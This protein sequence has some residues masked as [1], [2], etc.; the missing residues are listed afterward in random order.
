MHPILLHV[1]AGDSQDCKI[2]SPQPQCLTHSFIPN[3][4]SPLWDL[5]IT[6][7]GPDTEMTTIASEE[8]AVLN[9]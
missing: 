2:P 7:D 9:S 6:S 1:C 5:P 8:D 3:S 4:L